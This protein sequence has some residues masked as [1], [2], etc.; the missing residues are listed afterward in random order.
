MKKWITLLACFLGLTINAQSEAL[1]HEAT[2]EYNSGNYEAAADKY[3]EIL[4]NGQH[5]A[6]LY[7]NLGNCYYKLNA[8]G[9]SI[10]YYEKALLLDPNDQEV[11]N[12]LSFA[13]NMTLDAIEAIPESGISRLVNRVTGMFT[14]D[15]W[16][17]LAVVLMMLF[18]AAYIAYYY[19]RF[20]THKRIA[21][22]GSIT[23]LLL[24]VLAVALAYLEYTA[25]R[26]E[27]PAIVFAEEVA[28]KS[29]PNTRS[30]EAFS[31]HEGTKVQV[32]EQLN[33][34][35]KIRLADGS[36]GWLAEDAIRMLKDF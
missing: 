30:P 19:L 2:S 24:S 8:I 10:Y 4:E 35:K 3:L 22:I 9:P 17:Y 33:T 15:Q 12:N 34:W 7:F 26:A 16:A 29:E 13:R 20:A 5:S 1:F 11:R 23:S 25:F 28:V 27:Q 32:L 14:F 31:I 21:F 18:V 6:S 36:T